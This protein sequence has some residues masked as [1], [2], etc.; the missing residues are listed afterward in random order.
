MKIIVLAGGSD[1]AALIDELHRYGENEVVLVDYF[2]NPP[3]RSH[4]DRH[5]VA[6][7]LDVEAVRRIAVAERA[8]LITTACT[9]QALLTAARLS[10]ELGLP[11]YISYATALNVTNKSYMKRM[12]AENGIPTA[13]FRITERVDD[14][15]LDSLTLP[16]VVK[17]ADCNSS[18][19]VRRVESRGELQQRLREALEMSRTHTAIVEEFKQGEELSADLYIGGGRAVLLSV[20]ASE[21]RCNVSSF[22]ITQS[23]YPAAD[24]AECRLITETG[25][26]IADAFGLKETPLL[27]QLIRNDEGL[28]VIEFSARMGGGTKYRLIELLSGVNIMRKYVEL[29]MGGHPTVETRPYGGHLRMNY[30]YCNPGILGSLDGFEQLKA[31]GTIADYVAYKCPGARFEHSDTSSDRAA[32]YLVTGATREQVTARQERANAMLRVLDPD[33]NDIMR[34]DFKLY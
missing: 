4:S 28:W 30:V 5:I 22:T 24:A 26:R 19:G 33:G 29:V 34:H 9:D 3:A 1:Q 32:G 11:C 2:E 18:K 21:K 25:Q 8:D 7:T 15:A 16:L 6:S 23:R 10:E 27:V 12:M 31:D 13:R 17:P 14:E 20:T